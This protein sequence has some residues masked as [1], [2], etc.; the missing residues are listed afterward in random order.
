M[1]NGSHF[2]QLL[3]EPKQP[4]AKTLKRLWNRPRTITQLIGS[5][6]RAQQIHSVPKVGFIA[7]VINIDPIIWII[8]LSAP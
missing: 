4:R 3:G 8:A 6:L 1:E 2:P 7:D 5:M